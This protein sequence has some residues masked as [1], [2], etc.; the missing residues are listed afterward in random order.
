MTATWRLRAILVCHVYIAHDRDVAFW[1]KYAQGLRARGPDTHATCIGCEQ[2]QRD[3]DKAVDAFMA[4][5]RGTIQRH[6]HRYHMTTPEF[7]TALT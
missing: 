7:A 5:A 1:K 4:K 6:A 2:T 3:S